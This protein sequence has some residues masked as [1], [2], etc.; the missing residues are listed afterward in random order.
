MFA[1]IPGGDRALASHVGEM[2]YASG[3]FAANGDAQTSVY[4][5][6]AE[7]PNNQAVKELLLGN[8]NTGQRLTIGSGRALAFDILIVARSDN[9]K[10]SGWRFEGV[11][12]NDS[13]T[14]RFVGTPVKTTL[15]EDDPIWDVGLVAD[16]AN[17]ALVIKG[18]SNSSGDTIRFVATA[19]TVEVAW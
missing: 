18:F 6:R 10:S 14:V 5:L 11:I 13:G 2:A 17:D 3:M 19:R 1:T 4:V 15:G 8:L 9:A 12:E 7:V 16:E